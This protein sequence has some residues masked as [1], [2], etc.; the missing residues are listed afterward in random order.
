LASSTPPIAGKDL[1][2]VPEGDEKDYKIKSEDDD[3]RMTEIDEIAPDV[4]RVRKSSLLCGTPQE[5]LRQVPFQYTH[6]HLR[7]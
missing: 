7:D 2:V 6:D 5:I 3:V 1:Q 4:S